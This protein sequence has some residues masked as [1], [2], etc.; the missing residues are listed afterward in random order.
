[1]LITIGIEELNKLTN[2]EL[3]SVMKKNGLNAGPVMPSTRFLYEK[4]LINFLNEKQ[5]TSVEI[6]RNEEDTTNTEKNEKT[7]ETVTKSPKAAKSASPV[8]PGSESPSKQNMNKSQ[9]EFKL[10]KDD[11]DETVV[12]KRNVKSSNQSSKVEQAVEE[13]VSNSASSGVFTYVL[14]AIIIGFAIFIYLNF[15]Q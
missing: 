2:D 8:K 4:K 3:F 10:L 7:E 5:L 9:I 12:T 13:Q 15:L 1:M 14:L 11:V 6:E